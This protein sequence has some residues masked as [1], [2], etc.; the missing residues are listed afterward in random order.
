MQ[1]RDPG[2]PAGVPCPHL[3]PSLGIKLLF[4]TP[5]GSE[6]PRPPSSPTK[7]CRSC[8]FPPKRKRALVWPRG[9]RSGW[10]NT[11]PSIGRDDGSRDVEA[12]SRICV[13]FKWHFTLQLRKTLTVSPLRGGAGGAQKGP[14]SCLNLLGSGPVPRPFSSGTGEG[15]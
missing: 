12:Q 2:S 15:P 3:G 10:T 8:L 5:T 9:P 14:A 11:L 13:F 1:D 7:V 4:L 6:Q